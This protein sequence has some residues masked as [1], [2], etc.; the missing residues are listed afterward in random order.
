MKV[1]SVYLAIAIV[2]L[3]QQAASDLGQPFW[4]YGPTADTNS[5]APTH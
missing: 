1:T 3:A 2:C 5:A 4:F